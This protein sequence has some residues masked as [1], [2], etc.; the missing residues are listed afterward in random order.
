MSIITLKIKLLLRFG[1]YRIWSDTFIEQGN[2][3]TNEDVTINRKVTFLTP[4]SAANYNLVGVGG[5]IEGIARQGVTK[6][7]T[8][9]STSS[10]VRNWGSYGWYACGY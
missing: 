4:F 1:W 9:F 6:S 8:Y 5:V 10:H 7:N 2:S 3:G